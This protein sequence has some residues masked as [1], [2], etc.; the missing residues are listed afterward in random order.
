MKNCIFCQIATGQSKAWKVYENKSVS[1]F[2]DYNPV[3]EYHTLV[4][5]RNHYENIFDVPENELKNIIVAVK[6]ISK[7]YEKK[8]GIRDIQIVSS[9]GQAAQQDVFHLHFHVVPRKK[10]DNQDINWK[11]QI[12]IRKNFDSLLANLDK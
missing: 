3:S 5:P 8:L 11:P 4:I 6:R 10:G 2:F 12:K 9:S 1:A 7:I